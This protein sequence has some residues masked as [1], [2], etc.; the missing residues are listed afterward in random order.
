MW[1]LIK[2]VF[3]IR[4][5]KWYKLAIIDKCN[6]VLPLQI[7]ID[8]CTTGKSVFG[9]SL[10]L[11]VK[12][13]T[14]FYKHF[15]LIKLFYIHRQISIW[16]QFNLLSEKRQTT[17]WQQQNQDTEDYWTLAWIFGEWR[18]FEDWRSF[19]KIRFTEQTEKYRGG[20]ILNFKCCCSCI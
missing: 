19:E 9:C 8:E 13:K 5:I 16:M 2:W 17:D 18:L 7:I 10:T 12:K 20:F 4:I 14:I 6:W 11:L 1:S 15:F 3:Y